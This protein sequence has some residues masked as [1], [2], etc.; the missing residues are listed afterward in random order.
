M[1]WV[2]PKVLKGNCY[3]TFG[4]LGTRKFMLNYFEEI[5]NVLFC[6]IDSNCNDCSNFFLRFLLRFF[7]SFFLLFLFLFF[8]SFLSFLF[9]LSVALIV[10]IIRFGFLQP[11]ER[12]KLNPTEDRMRDCWKENNNKK[13]TK[14]KDWNNHSYFQDDKIKARIK[15]PK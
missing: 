7:P 4:H 11:W 12:K 15:K 2:M 14:I 6:R 1:Q 9:R 8:S 13:R 5:E 3:S 10:V